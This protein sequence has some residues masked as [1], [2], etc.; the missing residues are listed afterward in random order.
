LEAHCRDMI[1]AAA[2]QLHAAKMAVFD[3]R[4]GN[5]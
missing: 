3:E 1:A 5:M 4:S 2:R